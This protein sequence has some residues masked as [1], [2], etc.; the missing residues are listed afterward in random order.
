MPYLLNLFYLGALLVLSPWLCYRALTTGRY[1]RGLAVKLLGRVAH[2]RLAS[3]GQ[4]NVAWFHGVSVGEIHLLRP[5]VALF[6]KR[7]PDWRCVISATTDTGYAEAS[8]HFPDLAVIYW[9]FDFT[10]SVWTALRR[11]QPRLVVLAEGEL[12]PNFLRATRALGIPTAI[13]NA[14]TSPRSAAR[15]QKLRWLT[16]GLFGRVDLIAAQSAE[17][18]AHYRALGAENV[19][20]SG[21]IKYDGVEAERQNPRTCAMRQLLNIAPAELVWVAG[22]TQQ[23]EEALALDIYRRARA[24]HPALRLIL[25]PRHPERFDEVARLLEASGLPYARRGTL[26]PGAAIPAQALILIDTLGDLGAVWGLAD[27][28][29]VGGSL[30]GKRG[31]QNMIEPAAYGAAVLFGPH[32]WNFRQTV[33]HLLGREAVLQVEDGAALEREVLRLL[34]EP[35]LRR[36]LGQAAREFVLSQQG[37]TQVTLAHLE[38]LLGISVSTERAA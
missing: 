13:I 34:A 20:V 37:A 1:R 30:D 29:F 19:V 8:K 12:W 24:E 14:R 15:F 7:H 18:A 21:N 3:P 4:W 9:P 10:W 36:R 22:S 6:R 16:R 27:V 35:A 5:V 31:G 2:P 17:Y 25:V 38:T 23:P 26:H 11:V 33:Q 32:T 28:A